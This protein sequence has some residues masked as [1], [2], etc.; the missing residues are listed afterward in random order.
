MANSSLS[1]ACPAPFLDNA[2][3]PTTGGLVVGR[4]CAP[5]PQIE[6]DLICCLPCPSTDFIYPKSFKTWYRVGE[7]LNAL[8]L[9]F[10]LFLLITFAVL[11][12]DK[13]RRHYLSICLILAIIV[14]G[15]G[16]IV[17]LGVQPPQCFNEIT[18]NDMYS[19]LTCAWSGA[20]LISG[21]LAITVWIF[22]RA[23]SMH[24][25]ICW[26]I[27]P[28][29][30][31]FYFAQ[32]GGWG[33]VA[34][35]F[36]LTVIFTGFSFRFGDT[37]HV[38]SKNSIRVF[39]A[40]LLAIAGLSAMIQGATFIY[41]INVYLKNMWSDEKTETNGS[42]ALPSYTSSLRTHSAK[43]VYRRVRKVVWLQW[44]S[45]LIVVFILADVVFFAIVF[46]YMDSVI[47]EVTQ[48]HDITHVMPWIL[49]LFEDGKA[50]EKC[51][52]LGQDALV[53]QATVVAILFLLGLA[54]VQVFVLLARWTMFTGWVEW[55]RAKFF[56]NREFVSLDAKRFSGDQRTFELMRVG[57]RDPLTIN[58]PETAV[59][60]PTETA[61]TSASYTGK[62]IDYFGKS[63][64]FGKDIS[65]SRNRDYVSPTMSFS[66]PRTPSQMIRDSRST[67][68]SRQSRIREWD[69]TSTYARGGLGL[70]P[71]NEESD[72]EFETS[73]R[74][75]I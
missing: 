55:F 30:K 22:V 63:P 39:W 28:G 34:L 44:R 18:P 75:R 23:L 57:S 45:M 29:Q 9:F 26:D 17:P 58:T 70:H 38:N 64:D 12:A 13:T 3:F 60:S 19:N 33:V 43:A 15:L 2:R 61:V 53:N 46:I 24:L 8:G 41:C 68:E 50:T 52:N 73:D 69:P 42:S 71:P 16:F 4:L 66:S 31:F 56:P 49:C 37:C 32:A 5:L 20:L 51:L 40:P 74:N 72:D 47:V 25:Q 1:G 36:T 27:I 54:G 14:E 65:L 6:Q 7:S 59:I 11:P 67:R 48:R 35:L 62:S 21:G 10:C